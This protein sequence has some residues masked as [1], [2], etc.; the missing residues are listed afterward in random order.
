MSFI[1]ES[2]KLNCQKCLDCRN[3][4]E[5]SM[6]SCENT[7][8]YRYDGEIKC[9]YPPDG[10]FNKHD[11]FER[12]HPPCARKD[13]I[14]IRECRCDQDRKCGCVHGKYKDDFGDCTKNCSKCTSDFHRRVPPV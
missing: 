14:E 8:P 10:Y 3:K 7:R 1:F 4:C 12:C 13:E 11:K 9:T 6:Y 5:G 2:G